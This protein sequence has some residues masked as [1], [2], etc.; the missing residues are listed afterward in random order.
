MAWPALN[1]IGGSFTDSSFLGEAGEFIGVD[2]YAAILGSDRTPQ[3]GW[4]T[5]VWTAGS[6]A[7]QIIIGLA[8]AV[9]LERV[10]RAAVIRG[11]LLLPYA[12]P[13]VTL[14]L[15]WRWMFN[16]GTGIVT[17]GLQ[18]LSLVP[19]GSTPLGSADAALWVVIAA[20][21]WHG[22]PFAMLIYWAALKQIDPA[23]Y[24]AARLDGAGEAK[25]FW[26]ITLPLLRNAT[27]TL[28]VLRGI[29]T[30]TSFDLVWLTTGGGPAGSTYTWPIWI[31]EEAV[32]FFRPGR[33]SALAVLLGLA[34][35]IVL[36]IFRRSVRRSL[37]SEE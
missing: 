29:W 19:P 30:A 17:S 22:F 2:N 18:A 15:M 25:A 34:I 33:A 36:V 9:A 6:L 10:R 13:A 23:F 37:A 28:L 8:A 4:R 32:G 14:A 31:Y 12:V 21:V 20:N 3:V 27:V 24:E 11:I 26:H 7:G 16:D 35:I 5:V 1:A